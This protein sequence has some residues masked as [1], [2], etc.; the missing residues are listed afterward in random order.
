M[1]SGN[2]MAN[3][4]STGNGPINKFDRIVAELCETG[5]SIHD[6][7]LSPLLISTMAHEA[8]SLFS[9]GAFR[10]ARIGRGTSLQ[11]RPDIR[12][13]QILWLDPSQP[14]T[15]QRPY[16]LDLETLR[17]YINRSLYLGLFEYE[18]HFALYPP[19]ARYGIHYDRF[20]GATERV[21][22]C[23][24]Y[25]N[26]DWKPEHGGALRIHAGHEPCTLP[27][28]MDITPQAGRLVTFISDRFPHE[29]L[30]AGRDRLSLTGWFRL[31]R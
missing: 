14:S 5:L 26:D 4:I 9:D 6:N 2:T 30:E 31:R 3:A 1:N 21:V 27:L 25:L 16:F 8:R 13:D 23:I 7:F 10:H 28:P 20:I 19:G 11:L 15:V 24:L 22:T 29:V 18:G 12:N 17:Q